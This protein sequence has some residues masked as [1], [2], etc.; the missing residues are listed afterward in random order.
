LTLAGEI[1]L[2]VYVL[3]FLIRGREATPDLTLSARDVGA[4]VFDALVARFGE[5]PYAEALALLAH[6]H[7][8]AGLRE[9]VAAREALVQASGS[10][11]SE[12]AARTPDLHRLSAEI[13]AMAEQTVVPA[14]TLY[15]RLQRLARPRW[16]PRALR[17]PQSV[18]LEGDAVLAESL[19]DFRQ[20]VD[21]ELQRRIQARPNRNGD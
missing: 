1:A 2:H 12:L 16:L 5:L 17:P 8:M 15:T 13:I 4:P 20:R 10:S 6:H 19:L 3:R 21:A 14:A 7:T 9:K 18:P 11:A